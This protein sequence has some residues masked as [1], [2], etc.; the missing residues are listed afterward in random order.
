MF[1]KNARIFLPDFTFREGAFEVVGDRFGAVLPE[2]VP[3]DAVDLGGATVIP[4]LVDVH[5]HGSAGVEFSDGEAEGLRKMAAYLASSG[6]TS[7]A[8]ASVTL[9][10]EDLETAYRTAKT[11]HKSPAEGCARLLGI[12][13]EG[14]YF[15]E[16]KKGAQN[17]AYLKDP[18]ISGFEALYEASGSLVRIADVAPELPGAMDFIREAKKLCAVSVAH[19]D[20][21]YDTAAAAFDAGATHLTHLFN[22]MSAL[23]HRQPGVIPAASERDSVRAELICDGLHVHPAMVRLAFQLFGADRIVMVSDALSCCGL[24]DGQFHLGGQEIF[25]QGGIARLKNGV[26]AGAATNLYDCMCRAMD[27]GIPEA[28]ALR[29]ATFNPACAIGMEDRVGS[30]APGKYADFIL[31]RNGYTEKQVYLGGKAI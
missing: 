30:I 10:Y 29:A 11:F 25:L 28:D 23:H 8:P 22:A 13:M 18:D 17:G 24:P 3:E 27:M 12:H 9:P 6:I 4:G 14:P 1:F 31:C 15:S 2:N 7:F 20:A 26:I 21:D 5:I 19:T 16:A